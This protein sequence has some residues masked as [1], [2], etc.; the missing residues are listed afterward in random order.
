MHLAVLH[1]DRW[2][3]TADFPRVMMCDPTPWSVSAH[4]QAVSRKQ[5]GRTKG[6]KIN[7]EVNTREKTRF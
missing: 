5:P 4:V 2:C 3:L 7:R 6:T 1:T